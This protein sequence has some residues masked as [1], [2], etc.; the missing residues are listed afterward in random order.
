MHKKSRSYTMTRNTVRINRSTLYIV[1]ALVLVCNSKKLLSKGSKLEP[2]RSG[3]YV[4]HEDLQ[5]GTHRLRDPDNPLKVLA[6]KYN[7]ARLKLY[8][9]RT[10]V[11][12]HLS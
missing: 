3:P 12:D 8:Y 5:K 2:D 7:T 1:G 10:E 11:K 6:Q 9:Q 4:I